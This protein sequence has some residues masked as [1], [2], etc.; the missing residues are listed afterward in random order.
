MANAAFTEKPAAKSINNHENGYHS[1]IR[2]YSKITTSLA[3][4]VLDVH[5]MQQYVMHDKL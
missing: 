5:L 3:N 4:T 1:G 2:P